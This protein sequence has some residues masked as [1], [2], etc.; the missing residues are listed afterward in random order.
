MLESSILH[1]PLMRMA[2]ITR[3]AESEELDAVWI[4]PVE[5]PSKTRC[6]LNFTNVW[7]DEQ[8]ERH[9]KKAAA[10]LLGMR[11]NEMAN[12]VALVDAEARRVR[13]H[14]E[15]AV[16]WHD[17][18]WRAHVLICGAGLELAQLEASKEFGAAKARARA[19]L[20]SVRRAS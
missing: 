7:M 14:I 13:P 18:D 5:G 3:S 8:A 4:T 17:P 6:P 12:R 15:A 9:T 16:A 19:R 11:F 2:F 20:K 10:A 1:Q